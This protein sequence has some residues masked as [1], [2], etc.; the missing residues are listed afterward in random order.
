MCI[1]TPLMKL[2]EFT[3]DPFTQAFTD[4]WTIILRV[5]T[6]GPTPQPPSGLLPLMYKGPVQFP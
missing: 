4:E 1:A 3:G 2:K 6:T 5:L